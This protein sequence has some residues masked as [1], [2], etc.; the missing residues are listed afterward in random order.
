M[1]YN[2]NQIDIH[3]SILG[4]AAAYNPASN[5]CNLCLNEKLYINENVDRLL[6]TRKELVSKCR[7]MLKYALVKK[8]AAD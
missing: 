5:K 2:C 6:N 3:W 4:H 8:A 7:H 1:K